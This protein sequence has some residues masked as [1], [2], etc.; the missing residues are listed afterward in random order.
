MSLDA[1]K[2]VINFVIKNLHSETPGS[3]ASSSTCCSILPD[4]FLEHLVHCILRLL[5]L[6]YCLVLP[7]SKKFGSKMAATRGPGFL[8]P[9]FDG[10][11]EVM[12]S[13]P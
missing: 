3:E 7:C 8:G 11:T 2:F 4:T 12:P 13:Y 6:K 1:H 9:L 10:L 5:R